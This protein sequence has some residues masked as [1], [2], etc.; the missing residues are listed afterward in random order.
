M[1]LEKSTNTSLVTSL[2]LALSLVVALIPILAY[3]TYS[4][5]HLSSQ[6]KTTLTVQAAALNNFIADHPDTWDIS[7]DRLVSNIER[8]T[9]NQNSYRIYTTD[10]TIV[11]EKLPTSS[12]PF[13][14]ESVII[15]DFGRPIGRIEGQN[16]Y[17][18][19]LIV[20]LVVLAF[21]LV[22]AWLLWV[23]IH[24]IPLAALASAQQDIKTR[25][26]YQRALLDNFPFFV[27][28]TDLEDN[29]LAENS[30]FIELSETR[31]S[32]IKDRK[33]APYTPLSPL[34]TNLKGNS[35]SI[36]EN[37]NAER[38]EKWVNDGGQARCF[39]IHKS[40]VSMDGKIIGTVGYAQDI[41]ERIKNQENLQQAKEQADVANS[42]K[43]EFLANMSHEL[44]TPLNGIMGVLQ[45]LREMSPS[46]EQLEYV[47]IAI[48]SSKRLTNL[49]GDILDLSRVEA[50]KIELYNEPFRLRTMMQSIEQQ[51]APVCEKKGLTLKFRISNSIPKSIIGDQDRLIQIISNLVNNAIKF[52]E[53]G[54]IS[55]EADD[56]QL[57]T[58]DKKRILFS[59]SD[60]GIG[61]K[62]S[63]V[64]ELFNPFVQAKEGYTRE[65]QGAGLGL[66]IIKNLTFLMDGNLSMTSEPEIGSTFYISLPFAFAQ[67]CNI[68]DKI[69]AVQ[70]FHSVEN[71]KI[72]IAED[73]PI[74][75]VVIKK[76]FEKQSIHTTTVE[77]G[78]QVI[79]A[80]Q[81]DSFDLVFMDVQMPIMNGLETTTAIR[82]GKAGEN[83]ILIPIIALTAYAM[84][85]DKEKF[86][87]SGMD[88]YLSK[89]IE[90]EPFEKVIQDIFS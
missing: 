25:E 2:T 68:E 30:K 66:A 60:T 9:S 51:F 42:A 32:A 62:D 43:S 87:D 50:G 10:E 6:L 80:L 75:R 31:S 26:R 55:I 34:A 19:Q 1:R 7:T 24:G 56:I 38:I 84:M 12:G 13:I 49:L 79:E 8:Y 3:S 82:N 76:F 54:T 18:Y 17:L 70:K 35:K 63:Q 58:P 4:Y 14:E 72:L 46:E 47:G 16:S 59:V 78:K 83:N 27:W 71:I 57:A 28:L 65:H 33:Q 53:T 5:M 44:R 22:F 36:L 81:K 23:P 15:Y 90:M 67:S 39:E 69:P 11:V 40:P 41:T 48:Q 88:Y 74:S 73:D 77:N 86:L 61:I 45:I 37:G 85:G 20:G 89:P 21:S 29:S 64:M 52:T